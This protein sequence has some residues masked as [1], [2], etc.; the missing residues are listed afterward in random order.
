MI[1]YIKIQ[2]VYLRDPDTNFKT[3]LE[4]QYAKPEFEWLA[5]NEWQATEK[6]DGTNIRVMWDG[7]NVTING[8]SD[9]AQ[10]HG[11]LVRYL[12]EHFTAEKMAAQ[13]GIE[14]TQVCCYG[15]GYGAGIR[16]GGYYQME[17]RFILFDV[18]I[19]TRIPDKIVQCPIKTHN[20]T[21]KESGKQKTDVAG[22][23][24][25][26]TT[27]ANVTQNLPNDKMTSKWLDETPL[28]GKVTTPTNQG[29]G[30]LEESLVF[31]LQNTIQCPNSK[32]IN[33]QSAAESKDLIAEQ[34]S[35]K[36]LLS[37]I[38]TLAEKSEDSS[39]PS[40]IWQS[41]KQRKILDGLSEQFCTCKTVSTWLERVNVQDVAAGLNC[42]I[43]PILWTGTLPEAVEYVRTGFNSHVGMS[44]HLAEGLVMRPA[45]E[46]FNRRGERVI[47]KLK[48]ADFA[49]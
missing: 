15:E 48:Y 14:P 36:S 10:I 40:A 43:V 32:D 33:A 6:I 17:K 7:A 1:Q 37:T 13:F 44:E 47:T 28:K 45:T 30:I 4:G 34:A 41:T 11:D 16:S 5:N 38:A 9:N 35:P 20:V 18:L 22:F 12:Y 3:L 23:A 2:T 8:K 46:L 29:K 21:Q 19:T 31:P 49:R 25:A 26:E 39:A 42:P 27:A 24:T